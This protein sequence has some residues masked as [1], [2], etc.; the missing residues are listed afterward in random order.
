MEHVSAHLHHF[1][2]AK[3]LFILVIGYWLWIIFLSGC[4]T[5][6]TREALPVYNIK[7][8]TYLPLISLCELKGIDWE[9]D[10]FAR[11]VSL[12]K[13]LHKV[14][15]MVG[16]T[17]VLVDGKP[18]HLKHP[19]DIYQGMVVVPYK[20]K[21]KII[22][23]LFKEIP[24]ISKVTLPPLPIKKVVIDAGHGGTDPGTIG[25]TG[26]REKIVTL[27]L[28]KRL[29]NLLR[30][31]GFDV[32]MTRSTDTFIP[33]ERR[34]EIA[35]SSGADLFLSIHANANRVR[36]LNGFEVYYI[37]PSIDVDLR[38]ALDA[39]GSNARLNLDETYFAGSS[40]DLKAILWDMIYTH[41]RAESVRLARFICRI[42][43]SSLNAKVLG[44]K[45]AIF[46]VLKG[47][48]MPAVLIEVGFLSN[49]DEE[50]KLRNGYYRQQIA[51]AIKQGIQDYA[52]ELVLAEANLDD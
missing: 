48:Q 49:H 31:E 12:N 8:V 21:V 51:E 33:L 26:L 29:G 44:I 46:Y 6:P 42:M 14:N 3:K 17:L 4:A 30:A 52:R 10:P 24:S 27:D 1:M 11:T 50:R 35:N 13:D 15:L 34:V 2:R 45:G 32:V 28:A 37:S 7:G 19:V 38:R 43:D 16:E 41:N 18:L 25:K 20:F 47:T 22:D 36:G 9:Y 5:I 39:A 23:S 40:L